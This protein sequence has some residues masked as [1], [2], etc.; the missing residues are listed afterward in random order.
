MVKE[1]ADMIPT[2]TKFNA[3]TQDLIKALKYYHVARFNHD[4]AVHQ[5]DLAQ[6]KLRDAQIALAL[7]ITEFTHSVDKCGGK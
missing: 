3:L 6:E 4:N 7:N 1:I 5:W 2:E